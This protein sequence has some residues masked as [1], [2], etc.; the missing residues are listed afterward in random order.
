MDILITAGATRNPIDAMRYISARSSG[1]TG[2]GL[3]RALVA[4]GHR[5]HLM[6]SAEARLRGPDL[7]GE[8]YHSTRDLMV[9]MA[10]WIRRFPGGAVVH[11]AAGSAGWQKP[12]MQVCAPPQSYCDVH[13][14]GG[15]RS[16]QAPS[17]HEVPPGQSASVV[18]GPLVGVQKPPLQVG[19]HTSSL[20]VGQSEGAV[21][22]MGGWPGRHV[23]YSHSSPPGQSWLPPQGSG[24][25]Q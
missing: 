9:R 11:S 16:M 2:M 14:T 23:P 7:D 24:G 19:P 4:R 12:P 6:G 13:G 8:E 15:R 17:L 20:L 1:A 25:T 22:G 5:V 18:Q 10:A 3:A 21:H